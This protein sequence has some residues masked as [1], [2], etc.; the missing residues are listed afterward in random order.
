MTEAVAPT[1][2]VGAATAVIGNKVYVAGGQDAGANKLDLLEIYDPDTETWSLG[3]SLP[4]VRAGAAGG[5]I[6]G[7]WYLAGG[8]VAS[9]SL[10]PS[11]STIRAPTPGRAGWTT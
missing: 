5:V 8:V 9:G 3:A 11:S 1:A 6:D 10:T 2:R 4:G 7:K